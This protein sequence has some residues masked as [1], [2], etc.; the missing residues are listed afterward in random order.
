MGW[1]FE[2][3]V[4]PKEAVEFANEGGED[5]IRHFT[6]NSLNNK[7]VML[8]LCEAGYSS[9][10]NRNASAELMRDYD[11][12]ST[13]ALSNQGYKYGLEEISKRISQDMK[14]QVGAALDYVPPA[15]LTPY[16]GDAYKLLQALE[17][18]PGKTTRNRI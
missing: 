5:A 15:P 18:I 11:F 13:L 1:I 14:N 2:E 8:A 7:E 10:V 3:D 6:E 17:A 16:D 4:T 12:V 9:P